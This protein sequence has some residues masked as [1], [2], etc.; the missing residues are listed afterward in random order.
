MERQ[1][2][3]SPANVHWQFHGLREFTKHSVHQNRIR[4]QARFTNG[5]L[6]IYCD[7]CAYDRD[8]PETNYRPVSYCELCG[9]YDECNDKAA[10]LLPILKKNA[11]TDN[12]EDK[13]DDAQASHY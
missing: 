1:I 3:A 6:M 7:D 5:K 2:H 13:K 10:S 12:K 4:R 11:E 9:K 8:W